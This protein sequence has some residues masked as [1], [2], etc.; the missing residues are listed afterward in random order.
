MKFKRKITKAT[1]P[2]GTGDTSG[3]VDVIKT[4]SMTECAICKQS[5]ID[6]RET[7]VWC[8]AGGYIHLRCSSLKSSRH[9]NSLFT[10]RKCD[11]CIAEQPP[12]K[13][14]YQSRGK[15]TTTPKTIDQFLYFVTSIN[16][17]KE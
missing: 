15:T 5:I 11:W 12:N 14:H 2:A 3:I 16:Y 4:N 7:S 6:R 10:C 8:H 1:A 17:T 9:W 13:L